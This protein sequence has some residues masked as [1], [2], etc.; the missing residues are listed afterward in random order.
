MRARNLPQK[1]KKFNLPKIDHFEEAKCPKTKIVMIILS[2]AMRK[3]LS[4]KVHLKSLF[5]NHN[6]LSINKVH[7]II[8]MTTFLKYRANINVHRCWQFFYGYFFYYLHKDKV[9]RCGK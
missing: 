7:F 9:L 3:K 8:S 4:E 6:L 1:V 5:T 2:A